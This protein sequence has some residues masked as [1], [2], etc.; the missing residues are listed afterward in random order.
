MRNPFTL[1]QW[2]SRTWQ[3]YSLTFL[4]WASIWQVVETHGSQWMWL[5]VANLTGS[6]LA[7]VAMHL[8]N[9]ATSR[10]MERWA[11][12]ALI[13]SMSTYLALALRYEGWQGVFLQPN[14]GVML[15]EAVVC[16]AIH[17][18]VCTLREDWRRRRRVKREAVAIVAA[19]KHGD[20]PLG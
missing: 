19:V 5:S 16:A 4:A 18:T 7:L 15:S 10:S 1:R 14:L 11:Y 8:R 3:A 20:P 12:L 13:W 2:N 17:R 6:V 9:P